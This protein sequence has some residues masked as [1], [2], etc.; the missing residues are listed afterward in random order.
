MLFKGCRKVYQLNK[1]EKILAYVKY[2]WQREIFFLSHQLNMVALQALGKV[3]KVNFKNIFSTSKMWKNSTTF[4]VDASTFMPILNKISGKLAE[5]KQAES[6]KK[7][8][9]KVYV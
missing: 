6:G 1:I 7:W 4:S 3:F 9:K 2:S 8:N 5:K